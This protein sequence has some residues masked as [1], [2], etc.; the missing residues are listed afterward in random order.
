LNRTTGSLVWTLPNDLARRM[1]SLIESEFVIAVNL[2]FGAELG[3]LR[4][5]FQS[6]WK[7]GFPIDNNLSYDT[8]YQPNRVES[9]EH[10]SRAIFPLSMHH[11]P[12]YVA[13]NSVVIGDAARRVHPLA[14]QGL[15]MGIGDV[16]QLAQAIR[17][18]I[19]SGNSIGT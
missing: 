13:R 18:D 14:G 12:F 9:I 4:P 6:D 2:A 11:A 17:H 19:E 8:E 5:L 3:K 15:N 16:F 10:E 7:P 1:M